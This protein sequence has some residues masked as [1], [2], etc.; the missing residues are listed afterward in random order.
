MAELRFRLDIQAGEALRYY[1]GQATTVVA[2]AVNGQTIQFPASHIRPYVTQ[3][4][5]HGWFRIRFD[6]Q[7][8]FVALEQI[9]A[10]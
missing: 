1:R 9:S 2:K 4:G 3:A 8:K 6:A 5:I 10:N 7:N